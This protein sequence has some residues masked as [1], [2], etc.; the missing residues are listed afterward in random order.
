MQRSVK[1]SA[2]Q[3]PYSLEEEKSTFEDPSSPQSLHLQIL[4]EL[5]Q[6]ALE[7]ESKKLSNVVDLRNYFESYAKH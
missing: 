1:K 2:A 4:K 7:L 5:E 3:K 6:E